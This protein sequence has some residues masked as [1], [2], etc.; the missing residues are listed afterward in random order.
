MRKHRLLKGQI[1]FNQLLQQAEKLDASDTVTNRIYAFGSR[2]C[3]LT[4]CYALYEYLAHGLTAGLSTLQNAIQK[5]RETTAHHTHHFDPLR[6]RARMDWEILTEATVRLAVFHQKNG[7]MSASEFRDILVSGMK[8]F[9]NHSGLL[10]I[11][12]QSEV[13]A[14]ISGRLRGYFDGVLEEATTPVP[15]LFALY[16]EYERRY[17]LWRNLKMAHDAKLTHGNGHKNVVNKWN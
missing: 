7:S 5:C 2:H 1:A 8:D 13:A 15:W 3:N 16:A 9:P 12:T 6:E 10:L 14:F 11:F 17:R 4:I